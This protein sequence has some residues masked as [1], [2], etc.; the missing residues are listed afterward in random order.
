M[1]ERIQIGENNLLESHLNSILDRKT[2]VKMQAN[3]LQTIL[4]I[5]GKWSIFTDTRPL[6]CDQQNGIPWQ[7]I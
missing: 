5:S 2:R 7:R 6:C 4:L 3:L 1:T